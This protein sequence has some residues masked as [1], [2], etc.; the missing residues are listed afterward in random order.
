MVDGFILLKGLYFKQCEVFRIRQ[1]SPPMWEF[2]LM[3]RSSPSITNPVGKTIVVKFPIFMFLS[4]PVPVS[5]ISHSKIYNL[6]CSWNTFPFTGDQDS[7]L[8]MADGITSVLLGGT[9]M[10]RGSSTK[11]DSCITTAYTSRE[12]TQSRPG[13]LW[14]WDKNKKD[15]E[16][17]LTLASRF[18]DFWPTS[19]C[20]LMSYHPMWYE[21]IQG[22]VGLG[23][24]M[25]TSGPISYTA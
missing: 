1:P 16:Q 14:C 5:Y 20:G 4:K 12:A 3:L 22:L 18:L 7:Q 10:V 23:Q 25:S 9:V 17:A 13:D 6:Y 19:M 21:H 11:T 15:L 2:G 8:M 24:G